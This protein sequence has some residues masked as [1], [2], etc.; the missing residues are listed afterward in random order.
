MSLP[1]DPSEKKRPT[2]YEMIESQGY[3]SL[4]SMEGS[5]A[6]AA[7]LMFQAYFVV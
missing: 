4:D 3:I 7:Y 1:P 5:M 2:L 6:I